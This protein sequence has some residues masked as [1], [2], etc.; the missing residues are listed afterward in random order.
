MKMLCCLAAMI[1]LC[2]VAGAKNKKKTQKPQQPTALDRYIAESAARQNALAQHPASPGSVWV[3][4]AQLADLAMDVRAH[5]VND[6]VTILVAEQASALST[7]TVKTSRAS[8][9]NSSISAAAGLTRVAGPWANLAGVNTSSS[10]DGQGTTSR[11]TTLSTT[12]SARVVGVMPN[13]YLVIEGAK[14]VTVNSETQLI[15]VRGVIRPV[16]IDTTNTVQSDRIAQLEVM[17]NGKGVVGD[18][19]KRPFILWRLLLGL[20][21][22]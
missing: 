9:V 21:P 1:A 15:T 2:G 14:T 17:V 16:D 5:R 10:L 4:D 7:G 8:Q 3:P 11:Q 6:L 18:A 20:L 13:G 22:F 19:I 12:M